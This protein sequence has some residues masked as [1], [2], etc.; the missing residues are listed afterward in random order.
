V[1]IR[2]HIQCIPTHQG[3]AYSSSGHCSPSHHLRGR[4]QKHIV[5]IMR[6]GTGESHCRHCTL[7]RLLHG[8]L[9]L[10]LRFGHRPIVGQV[11]TRG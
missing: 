2:L 5:I 1:I 9:P 10:S 8:P 7:L 3:H 4:D 11:F 6:L